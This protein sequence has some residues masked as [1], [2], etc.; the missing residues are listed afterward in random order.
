MFFSTKSHTIFGAT[1]VR[2]FVD[3]KFQKL[4][5]NLVTL[6]ES[7]LGEVVRRMEIK[8]FL[9][10]GQSGPLFSFIFVF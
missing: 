1:F 10:M 8:F 5:P 3:K 2:E 4:S 6:K 9:K 7:D